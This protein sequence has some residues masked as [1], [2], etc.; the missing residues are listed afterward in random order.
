MIRFNLLS[1]Y[2][3]VLSAGIL[4]LLFAG[5]SSKDERPLVLV[6]VPLGAYATGAASVQV[7]VAID[8]VA[9]TTKSVAATATYTGKLGVYLPSGS[10]GTATVTVTVLDARGCAIASGQIQGIKVSAGETSTTA[11]VTLVATAVA[12]GQDAGV[13]P[14]AGPG[15]DVAVLPDSAAIDSRMGIDGPSVGLDGPSVVADAPGPDAPGADVYVAADL[16]TD[17]VPPVVDAPSDL[18]V[19]DAFVP[20]DVGPDAAPDAAGNPLQMFAHCGT[21]THSKQFS[22]GPGDFTVRMAVFTP[23]N[24]HLISFGDDG[25]AKVWDI[26]STGLKV[27]DKT[28]EFAGSQALSGVITVDGKKLAIGDSN[29]VVKI[30][31]MDAS[32]SSGAAASL[33]ELSTSTLP[34]TGGQ[35]VPRGFSLDGNYLVVAYEAYYYGDPSMT[36]VWDLSTQKIVRTFLGNSSQDW[37]WTYLPGDFTVSMWIAN[38]ETYWNDASNDETAVTLVDISKPSPSKAQLTV[39]GTVNRIAFSPD[40]STL[41]LAFESGEVSQWDITNKSLITQLGSPLIVG[42]STST[43]QAQAIS[44]SPDGKYVAAGLSTPSVQLISLQPKQKLEKTL[45]YSPYSVSFGPGGLSLAV[46]EYDMGVLLYCTP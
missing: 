35:A 30:F 14:D 21:Y 22:S 2:R 8:G 36:V 41:L 3:Q 19:P 13:G 32:L 16:R 38:A 43:T 33:A 18:P 9:P 46:G 37:T 31:D 1:H 10:N 6:D 34:Y 39:A 15:V 11:S 45:D 42:T 24:K 27:N 26:D 23:D 44:Y 7:T 25:R 40:G 28:L 20:F 5:C 4:A 12:C 29:G 17:P